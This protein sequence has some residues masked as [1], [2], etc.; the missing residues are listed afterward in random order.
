MTGAAYIRQFVMNHP[1]YKKDSVVSSEITY[2][3]VKRANQIATG[4]YHPTEL[5]GNFAA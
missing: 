3:L 1:A 4:E 5:L 2:D